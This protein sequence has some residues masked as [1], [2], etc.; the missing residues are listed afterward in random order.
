MVN[1][2]LFF[3][4]PII[5]ICLSSVVS[6]QSLVE[7]SK[8]E[9]ERRAKI[10]QEKIPVIT[11]IDLIKNKRKPALESKPA[12]EAA[13]IQTD[14]VPNSINVA[15]APAEGEAD[16]TVQSDEAAVA[17]LEESWNTSEEYVSLL[18]LKIGA[19]LQEFYSTEDIKQKEDIQREMN[20]LSQQLE[21]AKKDTEKAKEDYDSAKAALEKKKKNPSENK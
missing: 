5:F 6:S 8:K 20:R 9:K 17:K 13:I 14:S 11:N 16:I 7:F 2:K 12:I 1:K 18:A 21:K 10:T 19:L 4:V 3:S 15:E